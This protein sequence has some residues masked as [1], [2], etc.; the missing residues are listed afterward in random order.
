MIVPYDDLVQ[1]NEQYIGKTVKIRGKIIQSQSSGNEYVFSVATRPDYYNLDIVYLN[2]NGP[3]FIEGDLVD[4]WG[5][6][7][8]LKPNPAVLGNSVMIPEITSN[9]LELAPQATLRGVNRTT[10]VSPCDRIIREKCFR[11]RQP[12]SD[13]GTYYILQNPITGSI[14]QQVRTAINETDDHQQIRRGWMDR[15]GMPGIAG[16]YHPGANQG[17]GA[18]KCQ[19][20]HLPVP[21]A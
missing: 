16:L 11:C 1:N 10:L 9:H 3:R 14:S 7:D 20:G 6:V 19:G 21:S 12:G 5:R 2:Y 8:G 13:L 4:I 18:L 15:D 17:G